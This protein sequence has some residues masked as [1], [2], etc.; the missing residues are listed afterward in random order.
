MIH[1][2]SSLQHISHAIQFPRGQA[3]QQWNLSGNSQPAMLIHQKQKWEFWPCLVKESSDVRHLQWTYHKPKNTKSTQ[4]IQKC[5]RLIDFFPGCAWFTTAA[6]IACKGGHCIHLLLLS[7]I[8]TSPAPLRSCQVSR[9]S[10][11]KRYVYQT[12]QLKWSL[13]SLLQRCILPLCGHKASFI[14]FQPSL[15]ASLKIPLSAAQTP[16]FR[17]ETTT[18]QVCGHLK[19]CAYSRSPSNRSPISGKLRSRQWKHDM[20]SILKNHKSTVVKP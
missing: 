4:S 14:I 17:P 13:Y 15:V 18:E 19:C 1:A 7:T 3:L 9:S 16:A 5:H 12:C 2:A 20:R 6:R 10:L 8:V 11:V